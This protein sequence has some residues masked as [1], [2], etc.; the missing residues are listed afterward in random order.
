MLCK[1]TFANRSDGK[2]R[3]EVRKDNN[4]FYFYTS[5]YQEAKF[6]SKQLISFF[7]SPKKG[8]QPFPNVSFDCYLL[9]LIGLISLRLHWFYVNSLSLRCSYSFV[10]FYMWL[11]ASKSGKIFFRYTYWM[12]HETLTKIWYIWCKIIDEII[13]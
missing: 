7:F 8:M 10:K 5:S 9:R 4:R 11:Q 3:W 6:F 13:S 2:V 12:T 1:L